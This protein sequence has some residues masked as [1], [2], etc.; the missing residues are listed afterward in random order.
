MIRQYKILVAGSR[1]WPPYLFKPLAAALV[2]VAKGPLQEGSDILFLNGM[3]PPRRKSGFAVKWSHAILDDP[4]LYGADWL[5]HVVC[6]YFGWKEQF[7]EADWDQ[8]LNRAGPI[9]NREMV[10]QRPNFVQGFILENYDC[11]GTLDCL[12]AAYDRM[13]EDK[14]YKVPT[15]E[16]IT[17]LSGRLGQ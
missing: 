9:R 3:C 6:S 12:K 5:C 1:M 2:K 7:Y 16:H 4:G 13:E 10:L 15:I 14:T 8:Y 17:F 11:S